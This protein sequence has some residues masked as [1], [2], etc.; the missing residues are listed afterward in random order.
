MSLTNTQLATLKAAI[1][2]NPTANGYLVAGD[3]AS[4]IAWCN[5]AASPAQAAWRISVP[6]N[7]L[8]DAADYTTFDSLTQGKRDEWS[9]FLRYA[10]RDMTK[11]AK[12][13]V[14]TDVWGSSTT[15]SVSESI[16]L[17]STEPAT[18]AQVALGGN[19]ASTGT[20]TALKRNFTGQVDQTDANK[21]V[22]S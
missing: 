18:N 21:L 8:D 22:N 7:D 11:N 3:T 6:P 2:A 13:K 20:V 17:A 1:Q 12:R 9:I 15:G 14:V 5:A 19:T 16:L 4:L 10:P